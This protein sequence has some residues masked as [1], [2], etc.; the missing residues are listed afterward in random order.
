MQIYSFF[1]YMQEFFKLFFKFTVPFI[2]V[3]YADRLQ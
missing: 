1:N 3:N 2:P